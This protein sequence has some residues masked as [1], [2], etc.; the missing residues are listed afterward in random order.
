LN[1]LRQS[2]KAKSVALGA[3]KEMPR[4]MLE[5]ALFSAGLTA[6]GIGGFKLYKTV[7]DKVGKNRLTVQAAAYVKDELEKR[8]QVASL[9]Q[10][11]ESVD[12]Q[13]IIN[14]LRK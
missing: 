7:K 3:F 2:Q 10:I 1:L 9:K 12:V 8:A 13:A 11:T 14:R 6:A 5:N 4:P